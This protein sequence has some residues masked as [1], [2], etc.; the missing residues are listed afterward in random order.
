MR[1]RLS[2]NELILYKYQTQQ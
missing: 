1:I 2:L